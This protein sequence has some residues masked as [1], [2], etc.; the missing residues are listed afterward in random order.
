M[1]NFFN[2]LAELV[3]S[4]KEY[5][6]N[7]EPDMLTEEAE[8][9]LS[10]EVMSLLTH[11]KN[12]LSNSATFGLSFDAYS[13][14][15]AWAKARNSYYSYRALLTTLDCFPGTGL[16]QEVSKKREDKFFALNDNV[17]QTGIIILPKVY[18]PPTT[19]IRPASKDRPEETVIRKN[20]SEWSDNLNARLNNFYYIWTD[21]LNGFRIGNYVCDFTFADPSTNEI[22]IGVAPILNL[23]L[24][25]ILSYDDTIRY[26]SENGMECQYFDILGVKAPQ[27][28][29]ERV[30]ECFR[31]A[32][33]QHVDILMFPEM[34]GIEDL[35]NLDCFNFNPV[36]KELSRQARGHVPYLTLMPSIWRN[37]QNY[38]NVHLSSAR[39]LC[40]Q[41]KQNK[42]IFPGSQGKATENLK[43]I[44]KEISL[45]HV[46]GWGRIAIPICIDFLHPEYRDWLVKTLKA[47]ILLCP[48]YSPG[49][50]NFLQSLDSN[51]GYAV[52]AVW[53]NSCSALR[54]SETGAPELIGAACAPSVSSKSRI[55]RFIPECKGDC[56]KGC[57]FVV[58]LPLNCMGESFYEERRVQVEHVRSLKAM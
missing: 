57:L 29:L 32:C 9:T 1:S 53:L 6:S 21:K 47:D 52:H 26:K 19:Y 50:Y 14:I 35:Y 4:L 54:N 24:K 17:K 15:I 48:S 34:L 25:D 49:E 45:I 36:M 13:D 5:P 12:K 40:T 3:S 44:P 10:S 46:P 41:Y 11:W 39:R 30:Q 42:Y 56:T 8:E 31:L 18:K 27:T 58:T 28:I 55:A 16:E 20:A 37:N 38:V 2:L 43:N 7:Y 23:K 33:E 22:R 51:A